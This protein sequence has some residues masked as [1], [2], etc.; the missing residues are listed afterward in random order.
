MRRTDPSSRPRAVLVAI[1]L[2]G[3]SVLY[4]AISGASV[5]VTRIAAVSGLPFALGALSVP[6]L[7]YALKVWLLVKV[8]HGYGW[9]R[10][11][12]V[13]TVLLG[14]GLRY[15]YASNLAGLSKYGPLDFSS[16]YVGMAI[17]SAVEI[18][19][20]ALLFVN[21]RQYFVKALSDA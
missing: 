14:V 1:A 21:T 10:T 17:T 4:H 9:A 20:C 16:I 19:A 12:I 7:W 13:A 11:A 18:A 3:V 2:L 15:V 8:F 5:A 6:M